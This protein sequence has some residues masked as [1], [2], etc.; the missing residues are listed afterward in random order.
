MRENHK[1]TCCRLPVRDSNWAPHECR[2][3]AY[4]SCSPFWPRW[5]GHPIIFKSPGVRKTSQNVFRWNTWS[6]GSRR[7]ILLCIHFS[8]ACVNLQQLF[9]PHPPVAINLWDINKK[10]KKGRK[11][12][13]ANLTLS[14]ARTSPGSARPGCFPHCH[15]LCG[16]VRLQV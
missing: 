13:M 14:F 4:R 16:P 8:S 11:R 10:K 1:L 9:L 7:R 2:S 15:C 6:S 3:D 5:M 12:K